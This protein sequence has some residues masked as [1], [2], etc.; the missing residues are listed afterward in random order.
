MDI[1]SQLGFIQVLLNRWL[2]IL[3]FKS[4]WEKIY[5]FFPL[6]L[7]I[8]CS[9]SNGHHDQEM[10]LM[11]DLNFCIC[12]LTT[13]LYPLPSIEVRSRQSL[14]VF[15]YFI[16]WK[17]MLYPLCNSVVEIKSH[18]SEKKIN[19]CPLYV[20][21]KL[22]LSETRENLKSNTTISLENSNDN[23]C[24]IKNKYTVL[25]FPLP[26]LSCFSFFLFFFFVVLGLSSGPHTF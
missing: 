3:P 17:A 14:L 22:L 1:H 4:V 21:Q 16:R 23:I 24:K 26:P 25:P 12:T 10:F 6:S 19:I 8:T 15:Y 7:L 5:N 20:K 13:F 9:M 2:Y 18:F 11:F